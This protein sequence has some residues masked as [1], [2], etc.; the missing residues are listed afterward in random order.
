[1]DFQTKLYKS[2][3][4]FVLIDNCIVPLAFLERLRS[5]VFQCNFE[6]KPDEVSALKDYCSDK[7]WASLNANERSVFGP[8]LLIVIEKDCE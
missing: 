7:F 4:N 2:V 5:D 1:M 6:P 8:C 3:N